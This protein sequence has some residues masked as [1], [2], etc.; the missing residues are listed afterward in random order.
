MDAKENDKGT[1]LLNAVE[2]ILAPPEQIRQVAQEIYKRE[3]ERLPDMP[4][5]LQQR[6]AAEV[7]RHYSYATAIGGG[8][9]SL[10]GLLPGVGTAAAVLGGGLADMVLCLKFE[11]EMIMA[12]DSLFGHDIDLPRERSFCLLLAGLSAYQEMAGKL[13]PQSLLEEL[14]AVLAQ[15]RAMKGSKGK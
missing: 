13:Y 11:V 1:H 14:E 4:D 8:V 12:L 9:S 5:L 2:R 6:A 7:I 10:P 15:C 3:K